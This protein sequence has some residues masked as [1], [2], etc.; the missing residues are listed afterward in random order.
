MYA[1]LN[2]IIFI[3]K[4]YLA[5]QSIV[6]VQANCR[7]VITEMQ[8]LDHKAL[9]GFAILLHSHCLVLK[10]GVAVLDAALLTTRFSKQH[11]N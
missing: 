3:I 5:G 8:T 4:S 1:N 6:T 9:L 11:M 7:D 10:E 2:W